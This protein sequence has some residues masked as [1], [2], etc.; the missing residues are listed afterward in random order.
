MNLLLHA[1]TT[2]FDQ[3]PLSCGG[4]LMPKGDLLLARTKRRTNILAAP[5]HAQRPDRIEHNQLALAIDFAQKMYSACRYRQPSLW[6][7]PMQLAAQTPR[8]SASTHFGWGLAFQTGRSVVVHIPAPE[9]RYFGL[10]LFE[11]AKL[12]PRPKGGVPER[13]KAFDL[14]VA[15]GFV[16]GSEQWLDAAK[17]AGT[18][19]LTKHT[20]MGVSA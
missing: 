7:Q 13:V 2:R 19:Q 1:K 12:V 3:M 5:P 18:H 15:L 9:E 6:Q 20:L 8:R 14:I 16:V 17:E 4:T 11:R 10:N